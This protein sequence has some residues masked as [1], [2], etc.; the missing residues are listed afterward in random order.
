MQVL[1]RFFPGLFCLP[2]Y[3]IFKFLSTL[4]ISKSTPLDNIGPR[5]LKISANIIVPSLV[6]IVNKS[7][8][9][10]PFPNILKEAKLKLL[11]KSGG[12]DDINNYRCI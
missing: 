11:F 8:I 4:N 5:I 9:S 3:E 6:Y 7:I 2:F 1:Y 10:G 12:K